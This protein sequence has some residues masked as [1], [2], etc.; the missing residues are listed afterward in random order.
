MKKFLPKFTNNPSGFTLVELLVV[1][2]II[3]VLSII[4]ITIFSGVQKN[5]RDARR[6]ADID[7]ISKAWEANISKTSPYYPLLQGTWFASGNIPKDPSTGSSYNYASG[8]NESAGA[9]TYKVCATLGDAAGTCSATGATC[10][11]QSNQQ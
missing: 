9:D 7:S 10:Y 2:S 8:A 11:C 3:A 5:A 1:V 6:K 4:G